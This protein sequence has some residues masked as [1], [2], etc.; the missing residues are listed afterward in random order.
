MASQAVFRTDAGSNRGLDVTAGFDY[1]PGD[2][3]RENVQ[4]TVG[5]WFNAPFARRKNDR[6][7]KALVYSKISDSFS[8]FGTVLGGA[9]LGSEKAVELN[10]SLQVASYWYA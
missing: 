5:G 8:N 7:G 1:S 9:P 3:A 2:V 10:Y 4:V 6:V